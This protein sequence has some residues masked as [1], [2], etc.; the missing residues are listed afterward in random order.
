MFIHVN[1][2]VKITLSLFTDPLGVIEDAPICNT[3]AIM[4]LKQCG[5]A[6]Y[7]IFV[8]LSFSLR[9]FGVIHS[10]LSAIQCS[11]FFKE[12]D[13]LN[14]LPGSSYIYSTVSSAYK[15]YLTRYRSAMIT[16][17][18]V[19]IVKPSGPRTEPCGTPDTKKTERLIIYDEQTH[20]F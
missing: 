3:G 20:V 9:R 10:P 6:K 2:L 18:R 16:R 15:W 11:K 8:L 17:G 12:E 19:Y 4:D 5:D 7:I 1:T 13:K 14:S